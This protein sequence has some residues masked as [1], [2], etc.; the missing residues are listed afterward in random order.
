LWENYISYTYLPRE[1]VY[2]VDNAGYFRFTEDVLG[3][4]DRAGMFADP[5]VA[6]QFSDLSRRQAAWAL[7]NGFDDPGDY[8]AATGFLDEITNLGTR[9]IKRPKDIPAEQVERDTARILT[10]PQTDTYLESLRQQ[11]IMGASMVDAPTKGAPALAIIDGV[12]AVTYWTGKAEPRLLSASQ[13]VPNTARTRINGQLQEILNR[14]EMRLADDTGI[15]MDEVSPDTFVSSDGLFKIE[16]NNTGWWISGRE[17]DGSY[18][19]W[20]SAGTYDSALTNLRQQIRESANVEYDFAASGRAALGE[21]KAARLRSNE[22]LAGQVASK[23]DAATDPRRAL[24]DLMA[25][26]DLTWGRL[27][28][29]VSKIGLDGV[30]DDILRNLPKTQ[31]ADGITGLSGIMD[32]GVWMGDHPAMAAYQ[33]SPTAREA[34][35]GIRG[36]DDV[37]AALA[38]LDVTAATAVPVGYRSLGV[39]DLEGIRNTSAAN[40]AGQ[41]DALRNY[42]SDRIVEAVRQD[43]ALRAGREELDRLFANPEEALKETIRYQAGLRNTRSGSLTLDEKGVRSFLFGSGPT[44]Y[45]ANRA[46]DTL[47]DFIPEADRVKAL[48]MGADSDFYKG[49]LQ[50]AMGELHIITNGKWDASTYRAVAT[51]AIEGGGRSGL[52]DVLAPRLGIDVTRGSI[53]RTTNL[54]DS[55]GKR[56]F[57]SWRSPSPK[58]ARAL[59]QMPTPRKINLQNADE[60]AESIM[61][62]ARYAKVDEGTVANLIGRVLDADGTM[63]AVGVNRNAIADTFDE[64]SKNLLTRIDETGVSGTFFKGRKGEERLR[65]IRNEI[66]RSTRL[67]LGGLTDES[68]ADLARYASAADIPRVITSDGKEIA[69]PSIQLDTELA[70]GFLGLPSVESWNSALNRFA[71]AMNRSELAANATNY[72]RRFFDNFF[73]TSLLVFRVSYI[74]RNTA[75]MQVRMFLNG[76]KSVLSDPMTLA[77]M[78]VGNLADARAARKY[79]QTYQQ[80]ADEIFAETGQK[81]TKAQIEAVVGPAPQRAL[82]NLYAPYKDTILGTN[83]EVGTDEALAIAN[84]VE[85]YFA[86]IRQAHSLTDPRV[87]NAAIREGWQLVG[88]GTA[89][90]NDGWAHEL[91]MLQKSGIARL[92]VEGPDPRYAGVA[93]SAGNLADEDLKVMALMDSPEYADL[94]RLLIGADE[95]FEAVLSDAQATRQYLF[96]SPNSVYNRIRQYTG[97]NPQLLEYVRTGNLT[98]GS[99]EILNLGRVRDPQDRIKALATVLEKNF[100]G[101]QDGFDWAQHFVE[102]GTK[103]PWVEKLDARQ[104]ISFFNKF[105]DWANKIER[106]GAVGPEFRMAYWDKIAELAPG[107]RSADV[108]RA[109][110]AARTTLGPIKRMMDDGKLDSIGSNHPA[111][112][113]L[114]KASDNGDGLMTIDDLHGIASSYAA[115]V[116]TGLFYDAARR[117]NFWNALRLVFPFGQAWGNTIETWTKLGQKTPIQV[118]KAQKALN[119]M[120]QS[121]S[122]AIYEFGSEFGLYGQYA[123]GFA[124]WDQDTNGGFFYTDSFGETSFMYPLL[125]RAAAQPLNLWAA[126]MGSGSPGVGEVAMQSPASSLNLALGADSIFPGIGPI[127]ALP[128]AT[129]VLP[130]NEIIASI[131]QIAAPFGEKNVIETMVPSWFSKVLGGIGAVPVAGDILGPWLDVLAPANKNK[132]LRDAMMI[133]STSGNYADWAT[134]DQTARRLRDDAAGLGKALLLTTGL[135]QNVMPS[136]PYIQTTT[137][138]KGDQFEGEL[139]AENTALYTVSMLNSMF[140]QYRTRNGF[141]DSAAREEWVK[142]FGPAALFATTGDWKNLSRV[143]TSQALQ[144]ARQNPE[145]AK[146]NLDLFTLFFPQGDS[147]DVAATMWIRRYGMG[148]R[149][150][151]NKDEIFSEI[152][153][154]LERTQKFRIDS[155]E[156]NGFINEAEAT[157]ARDELKQRYIETGSTT[158]FFADKTEE[159]DKLYAFVNRYPEIQSSEAGKAFMEAWVVRQVS[160]DQVREQTGRENAGLGSKA[161]APILDWYLGRIAEIETKYPDFKLL[162]GKFRREWE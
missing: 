2:E 21:Y 137:P 25:I 136:T 125:G 146:A 15:K 53:S 10:D 141:D 156:A 42:R 62:Y 98:Y 126:T 20:Y 86:L 13:M 135:F 23:I 9:S 109:L 65:E 69:L 74:I 31:R 116:V 7:E 119:A 132:N 123:P 106:I 4:D 112:K 107:L 5:A 152:V 153:S 131:R 61:L 87:Y 110:K 85:D 117:N 134:N 12:E 73:R 24:E 97:G 22:S 80:A 105:F 102:S 57:R 99:G 121:G 26:P 55:D 67:W 120:I 89:G 133:L 159:M 130:D 19:N 147:S 49:L 145:I 122:S 66:H 48:D 77:G 154:F 108:D 128:L 139:E 1:G 84:H 100:N 32:R 113:A 60:V 101:K 162:A 115:E 71:L 150:R 58:I 94:R 76:H 158:G 144:F 36:T 27:L 143:P 118:Y 129:G 35:L 16:K 148:D 40:A 46:L 8:A 140:Q 83:F 82:A 68:S 51:N 93:N 6:Q 37:E 3:Y 95:N 127:A 149:E 28:A 114:Q 151:K 103:V 43:E 75:E 70:Q 161:A 90:F 14:P 17:A 64:I 88:Y 30:F 157:A 11:N 160:L 111:F 54:V 44:S 124:P 142:D 59:G 18:T 39:D 52:L 45:L 34:A 96:D 155:L 104:G 81:A 79:Q 92:V 72:A 47:S 33:I 138:L 29:E 78:T 41:M 56:Y 50:R 63:N 91:I 38:N